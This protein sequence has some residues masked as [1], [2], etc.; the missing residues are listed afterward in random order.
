MNSCKKDKIEPNNYEW[1]FEVIDSIPGAEAGIFNMLT[2][3]VDSG[4][5]VAY[6][7][8]TGTDLSLKYGYKPYDG[9]WTTTEIATNLALQTIDIAVDNNKNIFIAYESDNDDYIYIAE[10]SINGSFS[11]KMMNVLGEYDNHQAC[12]PA[13]YADGNGTIHISFNRA[14][15]GIYYTTYS[16]Q[17]AF[18]EVEELNNDI[19]WSSYS[20]IVVDNKGNK[21]ILSDSHKDILYSYSENASSSWNISTIATS[22]ISMQGWHSAISLAVDKFGNLHGTYPRATSTVAGNVG[23]LYK[24]NGSNNWDVESIGNTSASNIVDKAIACDTLGNPCIPIDNNNFAF[25]F[26]S[27]NNGWNF[28]HVMGDGDYRCNEN[29]DIEISDKNRAHISF[30]CSSTGVLR[31]ATR[32]LE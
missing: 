13:L 14:N 4:I 7:V 25:I 30:Y 18:T 9:V 32:I 11:H 21:H 17:G 5:H 27:E 16:F 24:A 26:A 15:Y 20:D 6:V 1:T 10:K 19:T 22:E 12:Y 31:Y 8:K 3:D 2:F 29:K 23:Y 28:E